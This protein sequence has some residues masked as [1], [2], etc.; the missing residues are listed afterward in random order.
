MRFLHPRD[1]VAA[2]SEPEAIHKRLK[3]ARAVLRD[4]GVELVTP[5]DEE[6]ESRLPAV[7]HMLYLLFTEGYS[8]AQ[9]DALIRRDLCEDSVK[10]AL[11]VVEHPRGCMPE[12]EAL[13][14]LMYLHAARFEARSHGAGGLLLLEEQDRTL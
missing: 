6:L 12:T 13:L 3:R 9:P 8:S 10:L 7:L 14:A 4:K 1:C 11:L 5:S 2:L